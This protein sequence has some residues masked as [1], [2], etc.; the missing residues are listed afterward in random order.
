MLGVSKKADA[1]AIKKAY[2]DVRLTITKIFLRI[3]VT[4]FVVFRHAKVF[5][6]QAQCMQYK[7]RVYVVFLCLCV[8]V[9]V[10]ENIKR[11]SIK[12]C[13]WLNNTNGYPNSV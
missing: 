5:T 1:K 13:C 2:Y 9:C 11:F 6:T 3:N 4:Y 7:F 10:C 8:C 12:H